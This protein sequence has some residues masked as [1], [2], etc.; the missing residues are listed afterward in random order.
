MKY[1]FIIIYSIILPIICLK[2]IIPKQC[3]NCRYFITD[4]NSG[5]FGK[6]S[7]FPII[8][9]NIN[10]LIN[11]ANI[12][13]EKDY[14]FCGVTRKYDSMCGEKGKLYKKRY[15]KKHIFIANK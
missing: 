13:E 14:F 12:E 3:F 1:F 4:N 10:F 7:L 5:I 2:K 8:E 9:K 6:C 15:T 11:D